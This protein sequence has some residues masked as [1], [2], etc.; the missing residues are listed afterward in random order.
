MQKL[1]AYLHNVEVDTIAVAVDMADTEVV[2]ATVVTAEV[3]VVNSAMDARA[4]F[5]KAAVRMADT[6]LAAMVAG[7]VEVAAATIA[8]GAAATTTVMVSERM[9]VSLEDILA[10]TGNNSSSRI[11][12]RNNYPEV[13][14]F[15][16]CNLPVEN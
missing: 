15:G 1:L 12:E 6:N 3:V 8:L 5:I 10:G 4:A 11:T 16:L 9:L 2:E 13:A 14:A 7:L